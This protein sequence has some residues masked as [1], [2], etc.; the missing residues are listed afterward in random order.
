MNTRGWV[1]LALLLCV[2]LE[3]RAAG[4]AAEAMVEAELPPGPEYLLAWRAAWRQGDV[5]Q[6]WLALAS[7][8]YRIDPRA[9]AEAI[10]PLEHEPVEHPTIARI[11]LDLV[12]RA[13]GLPAERREAWI[14]RLR[15]EIARL[16]LENAATAM[17]ALPSPKEVDPSMLAE[18]RQRL[19]DIAAAPRVEIGHGALIRYFAK[20]PSEHL[21]PRQALEL[22]SSLSG[23]A[24]PI[25]GSMSRWCREHAEL[26][27]YC[28]RAALNLGQRADTL[29]TLGFAIALL[30]RHA[31][32]EAQRAQAEA[33]QREY[34]ELKARGMRWGD[35]DDA[36][37][38]T[39]LTAYADPAANELVLLRRSDG[40]PGGG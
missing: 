19:I 20:H 13:E 32:D 37:A 9:I 34:Q 18:V 5:R 4:P 31:V 29:V 24:A 7:E 16:D 28:A 14:G 3:A 10:A 23:L 36:A 11:A 22:A 39:W 26:R 40:S 17:D 12:Q 8:A 33:W 30:R 27:P 15:A 21:S 6:R 25:F 1:V 38:R 2:D 35:P